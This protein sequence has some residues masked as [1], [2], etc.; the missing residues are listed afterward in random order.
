VLRRQNDRRIGA[1]ELVDV[2]NPTATPYDPRQHF[3]NGLIS[4]SWDLL[5]NNAA[6]FRK[7]RNDADAFAKAAHAISDFYAHSSYLYFAWI[8]T[9]PGARATP[10]HPDRWDDDEHIHDTPSYDADALVGP[11]RFDLRRFSKNAGLWKRPVEAA[12]QHWDGKIISGRYAQS[13]NDHFGGIGSKLAESMCVLPDKYLRPELGALPH[14]VE[15]AV[16]DPDWSPD[17]RL[18]EPGAFAMQYGWRVNTAIA[19]VRQLWQTGV[20]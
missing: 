13:K 4:E 19:H 14:H 3:D 10:F 18:F 8:A 7:D 15:I 11:N 20:P 16:D 12:I 1:L 6:R 17:H 5:E 9:G 2:L